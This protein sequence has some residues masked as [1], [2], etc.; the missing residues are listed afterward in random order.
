MMLFLQGILRAATTVGG[1]TNKKTGEVIPARDVLQI[2]TTDAR[3]LVQMDTITV[4]AKTPFENQLG[5]VINLPVRA[6]VN[7]G[8][9]A[10]VFE[11]QKA[12]A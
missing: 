5:K 7:S 12:A 9:V 6:W 1:G 2:E 3:G 11:A 8:R 4:P 10:F